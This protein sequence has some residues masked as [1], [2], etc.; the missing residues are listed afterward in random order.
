MGFFKDSLIVLED[1]REFGKCHAT[2]E[3]SRKRVHIHYRLKD[4]KVAST[5]TFTFECEDEPEFRRRILAAATSVR[6]GAFQM[7]F[8]NAA[9]IL[10]DD[11]KP[12]AL[13]ILTNTAAWRL[14]NHIW[15][16]EKA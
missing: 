15:T 10:R 4:D 9:E 12:H 16:T 7:N 6:H 14:V 3:L 5:G 1:V 8:Q 11:V 2:V 13:R